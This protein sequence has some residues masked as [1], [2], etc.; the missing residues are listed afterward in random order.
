[1]SAFCDPAAEHTSK[2][3]DVWNHLV[4]FNFCNSDDTLDKAIRPLPV[5]N[6]G[7]TT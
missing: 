4:S 6:N 1:M 2:Q 3:A 5:L 7:S